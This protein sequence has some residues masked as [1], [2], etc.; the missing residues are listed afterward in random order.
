MSAG[1]IIPEPI[2]ARTVEI[3]AAAMHLAHA[4]RPLPNAVGVADYWK[5]L[6]PFARL[7]WIYCA[8]RSVSDALGITP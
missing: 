6:G 2:K 1:A 5:T 8:A 7:R 4:A 3:E